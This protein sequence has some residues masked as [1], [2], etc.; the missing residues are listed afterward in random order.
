MLL[1]PAAE[2]HIEWGAGG[3]TCR[4]P[5]RK[6]GSRG[7]KALGMQKPATLRGGGRLLRRS[8]SLAVLTASLRVRTYE[9]IISLGMLPATAARACQQ[10]ASTSGLLSSAIRTTRLCTRTGPDALTFQ[11]P[12][13]CEVPFSIFPVLCQVLVQIFPLLCQVLSDFSIPVPR[14]F[15]IFV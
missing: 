9:G 8:F 3:G 15:Q 7:C 14:G 1:S 2:Q 6:M 4:T 13:L 10:V 5:C 11:I 12:L